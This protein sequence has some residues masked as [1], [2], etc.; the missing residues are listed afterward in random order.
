MKENSIGETNLENFKLLILDCKE[1]RKLYNESFVSEDDIEIMAHILSDYKRVLKEN[2]ELKAENNKLKV[3]K[4]DTNYGTETINLIPKSELVKINTNRYM[5]EIENGKFVDLK[6]VYRENEEL[7]DRW[8][9]DTH[10]LQNDLDIAN[11]KIIELKQE[12]MEGLYANR[13]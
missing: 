12:L 6:Q 13:K 3:I 7:K 9:K 5:I 4:Y 10:K 8:D 2:E 11:A 1:H